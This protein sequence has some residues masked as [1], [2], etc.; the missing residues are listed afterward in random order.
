L[1]KGGPGE[2]SHERPGQNPPSGKFSWDA[3]KV[4][5]TEVC[6]QGAFSGLNHGFNE[7]L[8]FTEKSVKSV[9]S[10]AIRDSDAGAGPIPPV[11]GSTTGKFTGGKDPKRDRGAGVQPA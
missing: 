6:R 9:S 2:I 10:V 5:K 8:D 4:E 7:L 1:K 11:S 3:L